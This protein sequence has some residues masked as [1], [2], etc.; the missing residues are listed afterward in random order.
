M[1]WVTLIA[2]L[3]ASSAFC[4]VAVAC[5]VCALGRLWLWRSEL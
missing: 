4:S 1:D 5:S 2:I 3:V